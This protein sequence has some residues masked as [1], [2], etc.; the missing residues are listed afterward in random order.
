METVALTKRERHGLERVIR[1]ESSARVVRRA[2]ALLWLANGEPVGAVSKRLGVVRQTIYN[3]Q[4]EFERHQ[5]GQRLALA[6]DLVA[7]Q[8][9]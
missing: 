3:W 7:D 2:Q 1:T 5:T 9:A 4:R 6:A 8:S